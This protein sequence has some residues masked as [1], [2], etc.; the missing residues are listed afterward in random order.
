MNNPIAP[1]SLRRHWQYVRSAGFS[2]WLRGLT[3]GAGLC[4]RVESYSR[5]HDRTDGFTL[6]E[7]LVALVILSISLT[8]ILGVFSVGLREE[9]IAE[10][11]QK[12]TLLAE[13]KLNSIG[14]EIPLQI[15]KFEGRFDDRF[16]WYVSVA[17]YHEGSADEAGVASLPPFIPLVVTV[18][19]F[20]SD[21][22]DERS[23]SFATLRL[24]A[25]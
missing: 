2:Q 24:L 14:L 21:Q 20:W 9:R 12:A 4:Q 11:R 15:G 18:T 3:E 23:I 1:R 22:R 19:V 25:R 6:I 5:V 13:S 16:R 7:V 17:P 10:D 8:I